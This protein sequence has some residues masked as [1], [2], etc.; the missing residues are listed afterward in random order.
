[1]NLKRGKNSSN[2]LKCVNKKDQSGCWN[3]HKSSENPWNSCLNSTQKKHCMTVNGKKYPQKE[4]IEQTTRIL[5]TLMKSERKKR[6][7]I[8]NSNQRSL[9]FVCF[10]KNI[11]MK[12]TMTLNVVLFSRKVSRIRK[13]LQHCNVFSKW[14]EIV[15]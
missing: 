6:I 1:M 15:K 14:K 10:L 11:S 9:Q 4:I 12:L 8:P 13:K 2:L 7:P 3:Q 5:L